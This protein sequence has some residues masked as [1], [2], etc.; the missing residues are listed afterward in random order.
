VIR[1]PDGCLWLTGTEL[2]EL[3][4]LRVWLWVVTPDG[5]PSPGELH[6]FSRW[7]DSRAWGEW[8]LDETRCGLTVELRSLDV[9]PRG[10]PRYEPVSGL[11][12]LDALVFRRVSRAALRSG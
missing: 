1:L 4:R 7:D 6:W 12:W 3:R 5:I 8:L 2:D 9:W 10:G 11:R